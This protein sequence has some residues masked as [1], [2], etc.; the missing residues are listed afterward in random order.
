[1]KKIFALLAVATLAIVLNGCEK[2]DSKPAAPA[3]QKPNV[4][5]TSVPTAPTPAPAA[6]PAPAPTR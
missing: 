4:S 5:A 2:K 6:A 1:M 3:D